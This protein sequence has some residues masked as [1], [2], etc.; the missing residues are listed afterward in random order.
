MTYDQAACQE[1]Q[2]G[3]NTPWDRPQILDQACEIDITSTRNSIRRYQY[4]EIKDHPS[5]V[6]VYRHVKYTEPPRTR[7]PNTEIIHNGILQ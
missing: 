6:L 3:N 7:I 5:H 4:Y 1:I 2:K